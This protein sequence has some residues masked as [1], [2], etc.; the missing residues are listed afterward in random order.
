[1]ALLQQSGIFRDGEARSHLRDGLQRPGGG[2]G[3]H[4]LSKNT[5]FTYGG[6]A[7]PISLTPP[8]SIWTFA[9]RRSWSGSSGRSTGALVDRRCQ[10][11]GPMPQTPLRAA[12]GPWRQACAPIVFITEID[13]SRGSEPR[14]GG[15]TRFSISLL[16]SAPT[17]DQCDFPI[18]VQAARHRGDSPKRT[19]R[20]KSKN[21]T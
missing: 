21:P 11:V 4:H 18:S 17:N 12:Q 20:L 5:P 1:M 13:R 8:G 2:S 3:D 19:W 9:P 16:S 6:Y 15:R 10:R 7:H 14:A